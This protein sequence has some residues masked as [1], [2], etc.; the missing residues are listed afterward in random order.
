MVGGVRKRGVKIGFSGTTSLAGGWQR[1][2]SI[3]INL[4]DDTSNLYIHLDTQ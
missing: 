4:G 2:P 3:A 1:L